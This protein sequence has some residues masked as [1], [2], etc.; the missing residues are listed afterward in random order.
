MFWL[1]RKGHVI[2]SIKIWFGE[3]S[4]NFINLLSLIYTL[5]NLLLSIYANLSICDKHCILSYQRFSLVFQFQWFAILIFLIWKWISK[6]ENSKSFQF[7]NWYVVV[8]NFFCI[9]IIFNTQFKAFFR[10]RNVL[11]QF[12][13]AWH[14]L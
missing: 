7:R 11:L 8:L 3:D 9:P 1:G 4:Y 2:G 5:V 12:K 6:T 13:D 14:K 10:I